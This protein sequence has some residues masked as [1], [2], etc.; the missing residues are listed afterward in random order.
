[1]DQMP[2]L[3]QSDATVQIHEIT[4]FFLNYAKKILIKLFLRLTDEGRT[5]EG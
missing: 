1:M 2:A 5:K 3:F 4:N